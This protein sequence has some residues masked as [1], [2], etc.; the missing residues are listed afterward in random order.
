[1][2][3]IRPSY[4]RPPFLDDTALPS[5]EG[6]SLGWRWRRRRTH[7]R[8][9]VGPLGTAGERAGRVLAGIEQKPIPIT[10]LPQAVGPGEAIVADRYTYPAWAAIRPS[11]G[12]A[13]CDVVPL[14]IHPICRRWSIVY[15]SVCWMAPPTNLPVV[16]PPATHRHHLWTVRLA[17]ASAPNR[18]GRAIRGRR[19][20]PAAG[21][22]DGHAALV[23]GSRITDYTVFHLRATPANSWP[24][25]RATA[26]RL[27]PASWWAPGR[28]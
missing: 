22:A 8:H 18:T 12:R 2:W 28:W 4:A 24:R 7:R 19:S 13:F 21:A 10:S 23:R 27:Y 3:L 26:G 1:L 11:G 20:A 9:A 6:I 25:P 14:P 16:V 15:R 17:A 5:K